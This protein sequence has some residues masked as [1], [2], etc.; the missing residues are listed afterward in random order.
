MTLPGTD[1]TVS[2]FSPY[3]DFKVLLPDLSPS[4]FL[5]PAALNTFPVAWLDGTPNCWTCQRIVE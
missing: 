5:Q 1:M 3:P 4:T 2:S